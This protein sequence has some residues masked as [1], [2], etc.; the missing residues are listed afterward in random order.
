MDATYKAIFRQIPVGAIIVQ[1]EDRA[2]FTILDVNLAAAQAGGWRQYK[3]GNVIGKN[4]ADIFEGLQESGLLDRYNEAL[5]TQMEVALGSFAYEDPEVPY[6]IFDIGLLPLSKDDLLVTYTNVTEQRQTEEQLRRKEEQYRSVVT[7]LAEGVS[8]YDAQANLLAHNKSAERILGLNAD[9]MAGRSLADPN[10]GTIYEDGSP[11]PP[12]AYPAMLTLRGGEPMHNQIMGVSKPDGSLTWI[13]INTEPLF[14]KGEPNPA[15]VV[16]SFTDITDLKKAEQ[17][18]QT[19]HEELEQ[20]IAERTTELQK[21]NALLKQKIAEL[22][23]AEKE[24]SENEN[25]W[26]TLVENIGLI[27]ISLDRHGNVDFVNPHFTDITG[28]EEEDVLGKHWFSHFLPEGQRSEV[29]DAFVALLESDFNEQY[30]NAIVTKD[31][32]ERIIAWSNTRTYDR[33]GAI[34]GSFSIGLDIT[35][36]EEVEHV[37]RRSREELEQLVAERTSELSKANERLKR[38]VTERTQA[39]AELEA[40][41]EE[42]EHFAYTVSHDL[43][44]PLFTI[45]GFI[46]L[47][48]KDIER[49]RGDRVALN[50]KQI[51]NAADK[52][53]LLLGKILELSRIGRLA[54]PSEEIDLVALVH[55]AV[56][57]VRGNVAARGVAVQVDPKL[58]IVVGDRVRLQQVFQNLLENAVKF[59]G[60][61][62][63]PYV[64][65]G[66]REDEGATV[67]FVKDNGMGI[68]PRHQE[69]VFKLFERLN[70]RAEG[71]GFGL[72]LV[73][74]IIE[75]HRG[76]IWVESE[77]EGKGS[78]FCFTLGEG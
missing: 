5:D 15:A 31:D 78:T 57:L 18:L 52:M 30:Q 56:D 76:R 40:K 53:Q 24:T 8:M 41:N 58:P 27:V 74:R 36:R 61:Q 10:W 32:E 66:V 14:E 26:R 12:E 9:Q 77:G 75:V 29:Y 64:K 71:S 45:K 19:S 3:P 2:T 17:I 38:E 39:E 54:N 13:S 70:P 68:A 33:S 69:K 60:E 7:A 35:E 46:G 62:P 42:L 50:I 72:S 59:M 44:S 63:A 43:K 47:L 21:A 25:R 22:E 55:E 51:T 34:I 6:G 67:I 1:R 23:R 48:E 73:N 65:V 16:A 49:G 20:R 37:L 4:I 28:F 11:Y